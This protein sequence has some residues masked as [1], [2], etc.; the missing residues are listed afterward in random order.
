VEGNGNALGRGSRR[1]RQGRAREND[2]FWNSRLS[3]TCSLNLGRSIIINLSISLYEMNEGLQENLMN[4]AGP[5][6]LL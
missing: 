4:L 5:D 1:Y 3:Q 6:I 2:P